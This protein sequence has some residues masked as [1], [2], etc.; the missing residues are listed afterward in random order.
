LFDDTSLIE[1]LF[2]LE[3]G[4]LG[5]FQDGIHAAQDAHGQDDIGVLAA[6]EEVA[7]NVVGDPPDE[8][9][10]LVVGGLVHG[11]LRFS[12]VMRGRGETARCEAKSL[13]VA[14]EVIPLRQE[15]QGGDEA[16]RIDGIDESRDVRGWAL[17]LLAR[18]ARKG[19]RG[20]GGTGDRGQ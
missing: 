18:G 5:R 11:H 7:E 19:V 6:F 2:G 15:A 10:D 1:H 17:A 3:N 9:N 12:G 8:G 14:M 20:E 4:L 16:T 13:G